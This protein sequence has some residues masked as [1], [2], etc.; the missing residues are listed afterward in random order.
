MQSRAP[1]YLVVGVSALA[2]AVALGF[3]I[4]RGGEEPPSA[5]TTATSNELSSRTSP[6][7]HGDLKNLPSDE[8]AAQAFEVAFGTSGSAV[9]KIGEDQEE[10]RFSP[11][12]VVWAPFGPV[13]LSEG[14]VI[15]F[16]HVSAGKLAAVYLE[17]RG[18]TFQVRRKFLPVI[19]S[20]SMGSLA[21]WSVSSNV[22][23]Y[24]VVY[25]EGGGT[26]QGYTC[27]RATLLELMPEKPIELVDIPVYYS[28][29]GAILDDSKPT[30]IDGKIANVSKGR[31]FDVVYRGTR[32]FTDHYV[33]RANRYVLQGGPSAMDEC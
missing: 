1:L 13:L 26:W 9:L 3:V 15:D 12:K 23:T 30:E 2:A 11:G 18:N 16:G 7:A 14:K 8:Q 10:T 4:G 5:M 25:V 6:E 29:A 20:G 31:S 24:P 27:S 33:R 22:S 19:E 17:P 21:E 28:N 32:N